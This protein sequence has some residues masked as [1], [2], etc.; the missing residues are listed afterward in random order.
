MDN[1][2]GLSCAWRRLGPGLA[3]CA[4][5]ALS[6]A[7]P[8]ASDLDTALD[9]ARQGQAEQAEAL[10][11]KILAAPGTS[12]A[13]RAAV[14]IVRAEVLLAKALLSSSLEDYQRLV[15]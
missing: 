9:L 7:L 5:L 3:I 4:A 11:K 12:P 2:R 6:P 1:A 15:E 13:D 8:A 14:E 10:V